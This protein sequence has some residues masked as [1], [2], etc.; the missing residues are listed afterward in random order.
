MTGLTWAPGFHPTEMSIIFV[1]EANGVYMLN[2]QNWHISN[3][4]NFSEGS[5]KHPDLSLLE[6]V[7]SFD[8]KLIV[9][10]LDKKDKVLVKRSYSHLLK[11][12]LQTASIR[13]SCFR[14]DFLRK[15]L[16]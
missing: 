16:E 7:D 15:R 1:R 8:H 3:L 6:I 2:T 5:A 13:A 14:A 9:Y 12:C 11:F 4:I 10:T